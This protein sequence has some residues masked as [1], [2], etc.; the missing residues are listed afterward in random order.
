[1]HNNRK[2]LRELRDCLKISSTTALHGLRELEKSKLVFQD[3]NRNY[4]LTNIGSIMAVK[5]LDFCN[6]AEVLKKHERFWLEHDMSGIPE[7]LIKKIEWLKDSAVVTDTETEIFK[8]HSNFINLLKNAKEI[9]GVSSI[10]VPEFLSLFEELLNKNVNIRLVL[11]EEVL[12]KIDTTILKKFITKDIS[13][14]NLFLMEKNMKVAI[15]VTDYFL[16][17]GLFR[18]D[19][20]YDY[21]NDLIS[22][23]KE[24]I[25]WGKEFFEHY[26]KLSQRVVL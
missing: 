19:G 4:L 15:T 11:T 10:C 18:M 22:Y 1:M 21:S 5:L 20:T 13:N 2:S 23:N 14:F 8:V 26:V 3:K 24:A 17:L 6:A 16:S 25:A 12:E 7:H 9:N